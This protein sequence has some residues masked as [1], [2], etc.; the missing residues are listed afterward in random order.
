[1]EEPIE[2]LYFDWLC[3]MVKTDRTANY[4]ELFRIMDSHEFIAVHAADENRIEDAKELRENFL[5]E[6][7]INDTSLLH[8][9][10]S[11]FEVLIAFA[12]RAAF[13]IDMTVQTWFWQ[14]IVNLKLEDYSR[15]SRSDRH[16]IDDILDTFVMREYGPNGEGGLFPLRK[17]QHDQRKVEIWYQFCE[18]VDDNGLLYELL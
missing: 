4:I 12:E 1:M 14:F 10:C 9:K 3:A 13:Q 18:Y 7:N 5:I 16:V 17:P 2:H 8:E 6:M 11:I 15:A